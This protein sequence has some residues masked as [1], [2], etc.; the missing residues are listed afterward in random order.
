MSTSLPRYKQ[1]YEALR[2]QILDGLLPPGTRLPSSRI[3]A[4]QLKLSRNTAIAALSQLCAEGYAEARPASGIYVLP[5]LPAEWNTDSDDKPGS[6][7]VLN[8]SSRGLRI[9]KDAQKIGM[10]GAFTPGIPD[11]K[12]F[13]FALWQRYVARYARNPRLSWQGYPCQGGHT[14]LRQIIAEYLRLFRGIRCDAQQILITHGTQSSLQLTANLLTDHEDCV[15]ME[16]PGYPG[17]HSAF[18]A[19]GLTVIGQPVDAEGLA[20]ANQAWQKPPRLIYVT[21]SHQYPLGMVMTAARRR[22]LLTRAAQHNTWFIEDDYDSEFRYSNAPLAAMQALSPQQVIYL[23]TFSK[24]LFPAL[25]VGYMVLPEN[26]VDAF[27]ATQARHHREPA[28]VVQSALTDF[29]RDGHYNAHVRKMRYKYQARQEALV[30]LFQQELGS[31]VQWSGL[32][33][34]LHLAALLPSGIDDWVVET[35]ASQQ[36]VIARCLQNYY[37]PSS[38][39]STPSP[40]LVLGFGDAS[41]Q[42]IARAGKILARI[43]L[44]QT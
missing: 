38:L 10:R 41:P 43:L 39:I 15:W 2:Q 30:R 20:P 5:T 9:S 36:G 19:A 6:T 27:R 4:K 31:L 23:G 24:T 12:N 3:L 33:T 40:G 11:L 14:E 22:Q 44:R 34:G 25:R 7:T 35:Q 18:T 42:D 17:A 28:Y 37:V 26:I 16:N 1:L 13:P 29:I 8:L 32:D 21:P